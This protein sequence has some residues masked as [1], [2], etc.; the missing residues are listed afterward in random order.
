MTYLNPAKMRASSPF[1]KCSF[2]S[3]PL[4]QEKKSGYKKG[5]FNKKLHKQTDFIDPKYTQKL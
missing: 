5:S 3:T 1:S 2:N 4:T